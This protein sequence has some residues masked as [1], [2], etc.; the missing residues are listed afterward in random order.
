[1]GVS[2]C[3]KSS[4]GAALTC[5]ALR[6]IYREQLRAAAPGLRFVF[7]E[8]ERA[9]AERCVANQFATLQSPVGAAGVL[10]M[11][12]TALLAQSVSAVKAW[13]VSP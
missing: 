6:R 1:M 9:E 13:L 12:A 10:A 3:C 5:S 4:L 11:D 2:G 8:I 7:M